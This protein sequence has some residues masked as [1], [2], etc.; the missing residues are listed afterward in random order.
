MGRLAQNKA[1]ARQWLASNFPPDQ[2][3]FD[4]RTAPQAQIDQVFA[5]A[6]KAARSQVSQMPSSPNGG[7][8]N[9]PVPGRR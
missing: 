1:Q 4:A 9:M 6:Q 2:L 8:G 7:M 3:G 5:A